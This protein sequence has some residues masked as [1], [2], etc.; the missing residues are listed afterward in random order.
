MNISRK[1]IQVLLGIAWLFDGLFQLKPPM[2]TTAFVK[3]VILP[4]AS[5]EPHWIQAIVNWGAQLTLSHTV[6]WNAT[7]ALVQIGIGLALFFNFKVRATLV[8]SMAWALVVW[9]FGEAFGQLFTGQQLV[10]SGAPGAALVYGFVAAAVWPSR[11]DSQQSWSVFGVRFARYALAAVFLAGAFLH[12]QFAFLTQHGF[13][14]ALATPWLTKMVGSHSLGY[15]ITV[16]VIEL[17]IAIMLISKVQVRIAVWAGIVLS[18]LFWWIGQ[19]FGQLLDPL[20]TDF[21]SAPILVLLA[22]SA[23]GQP[24]TV[25]RLELVGSGSDHQ[26]VLKRTS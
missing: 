10:L 22:L 4:T 7:F 24:E 21:N 1:L 14:N 16:A 8:V 9:V 3:Q 18:L 23:L 15:S 5:G 17:A 26:K 2:F 12:A 19:S 13:A 11:G 25:R 6:A 20:A